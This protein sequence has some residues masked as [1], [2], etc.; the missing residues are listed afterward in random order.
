MTSPTLVEPRHRDSRES[1]ERERGVSSL[2]RYLKWFYETVMLLRE[3]LTENGTI[4]VH[5]DWHVI[6]YA[7]AVL[8]EVFGQDR[9]EVEVD[10]KPRLKQPSHSE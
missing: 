7:K 6:H 10:R 3:L 1:L 8:D 4:Y 9:F 2:D 5:L